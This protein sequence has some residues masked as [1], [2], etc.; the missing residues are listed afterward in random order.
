M[1]DDGILALM[2]QTRLRKNNSAEYK[3]LQS[4]MKKKIRAAKHLWMLK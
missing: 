2:E 3:R 1:G 4:L